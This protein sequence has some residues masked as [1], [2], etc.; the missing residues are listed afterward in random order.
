MRKTVDPQGARSLDDLVERLRAVRVAADSPSFAE[1]AQRI[2]VLRSTRGRGRGAQRPGRVT[3]YDVFRTGRARIDLD[4]LVD[5]VTV[6]DPEQDTDRW[7]TAHR[8]VLGAAAAE[9]PTSA[10]RPR[11]SALTGTPPPLVGRDG[12]LRRLEEAVTGAPENATPVV[13][14]TGLPGTGK[15]ALA[16]TL[17]RRIVGPGQVTLEVA[18]RVGPG[19]AAAPPAQLV[20]EIAQ[21]LGALSARNPTPGHDRRCVVVL[22]DAPDVETVL[23][24]ADSLPVGS[25]LVVGSR[26]ALTVPDAITQRLSSLASR[27]AEA[28]LVRMLAEQ[29]HVLDVEADPESLHRLVQLGGTIPLGISVLAADIRARPDWA[30]VDHLSRLERS[31]DPLV[32]A[33]GATYEELS[34]DQATTLRMLALHPARLDVAEIARLVPDTDEAEMAQVLAVLADRHL[35]EVLPGGRVDLHDIVRSFALARSNDVDPFSV[36]A[37]GISRLVDHLLPQA[38]AAATASTGLRVDST[39]PDG[40]ADGGADGDPA[41]AHDAAIEWFSEHLEVLVTTTMLAAD[42]G[43]AERVSALSTALE[44]TLFGAGRFTD[45]VLVHGTAVRAGTPADRSRAELGYIESLMK[46]PRNDEALGHLLRRQERLGGTDVGTLRLLALVQHR[47]G[48]LD[49]AMATADAAVDAAVLTDDPAAIGA[50]HVMRAELL[51]IVGRF[52]ESTRD[53]QIAQEQAERAGD[54]ST[55]AH[56]SFSRAVRALDLGRHEEAIVHARHVLAIAD[57]RTEH[58]HVT[59]ARNVLGAALCLTGHLEEG[60]A[61]LD[62]VQQ[63][64]FERGARHLEVTV[65]ILI[66]RIHVQTGHPEVGAPLLEEVLDLARQLRLT[67]RELYVLIDLGEAHLA[68]GDVATAL[69]YFERGLAAAREQANPPEEARAIAGLGDVALTQGDPE[70]ARRIWQDGHEATGEAGGAMLTDRLAAL[71][72]G[73]T[74]A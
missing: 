51:V 67:N 64:A 25:R 55:L 18:T 65:R 56:V 23:A 2:G 39:V 22:D 28:L 71:G 21:V 59:N 53:Q 13:V 5:I 3:V 43:L 11:I 57:D 60:F 7:R 32:P 36:R 70:R 30:L 72:D 16:R 26:R 31:S 46:L 10:A 29:G 40:G 12:E 73:D 6:L 47:L 41:G 45:A 15:T 50:A 69:D 38:V 54:V 74:T 19:A 42:H 1:I 58:I 52:E 37:A 14:I 8:A 20:A 63:I 17:A 27:D 62:Q 4:L 44:P 33:L 68:L 61:E 66:G 24:V 9:P 35:V 49:D 34:A 48:R